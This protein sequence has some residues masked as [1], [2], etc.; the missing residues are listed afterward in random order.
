MS[1][2]EDAFLLYRGSNAT[3]QG[4][5]CLRVNVWTP[6]INGTA[7]RPVMVWM[8][9]GGFL[10]GSGHDLLSYDGENL[11]RRHDAVVVTHNHRL[12]AF[13]YL[14]LAELGGEKYRH[15]ANVGLLDLVAVL[16]WVRDNIARFGGDP[17]KVTIFGQSGGG[18]KVRALM[19]MPAAKG[20]FHRAIVQSGSMLHAGTPEDTG[21]LAAAY[22]AE[23]GLSKSELDKLHTIPTERLTTAT[24]AAM[25][26][27]GP[28]T[29]RRPRPAGDGPQHG[30][31]A[32]RRRRRPP[33]APLRPFGPRGL[34]RR[35]DAD[36]HQPQ[37]VRPR[38]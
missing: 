7:N 2:D 9:G 5:D 26:E 19:A 8:H 24:F 6:E 30:L 20:L 27:V 15:S 21:R 11:A 4:E 34:R 33:V 38:R 35:A 12:N 10:A 29:R 23:L 18:G 28:P 13:G 17:N 16:E 14:N 22:L 36:R 32:N 1:G 31:G 37:R 25:R 3:S